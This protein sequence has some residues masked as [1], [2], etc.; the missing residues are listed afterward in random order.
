MYISPEPTA[1]SNGRPAKI[2]HRASSRGHINEGWLQSYH[3]FSHSDHYD[4]GQVSFGTLRILNEET[5]APGAGFTAL[6]NRNMEIVHIP[7][8]GSLEYS[9][10]LGNSAVI[11]EGEIQVLSAGTG[12]SHREFNARRNHVLKFLQIWVYPDQQDAEPRYGKFRLDTSAMDNNLLEIIGPASSA[13][14]ASIRQQAWFHMGRLEKDYEIRYRLRSRR[15]GVYIYMIKGEAVINGESLRPYDG[16]GLC[17]TRC[18]DIRARTG[19][20]LLLMEVPVAVQ[21]PA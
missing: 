6:R 13:R 21:P 18:V 15:N 14:G 3:T 1:T 12:I 11:G 4:P 8:E 7:L 2:I 9:D 5:V 19:A 20:Q 16:I 17:K 10:A